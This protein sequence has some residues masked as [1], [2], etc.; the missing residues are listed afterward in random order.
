MEVVLATAADHDGWVTY[1]VLTPEQNESVLS[2]QEVQNREDL[3][4]EEFW[5]IEKYTE[6]AQENDIEIVDS[7]ETRHP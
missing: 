7:W 6:W 3:P 4:L 2:I 1:Y 5:S